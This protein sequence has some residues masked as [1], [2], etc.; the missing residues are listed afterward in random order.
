MIA[1]PGQLNNRAELYH[2]LGV[3]VA[4]G[5]P[6][7]KALEM[8]ST[9]PATRGSRKTIPA[10]IQHLNS[11]L[12][13]SDSMTRVQGW[14][15]EFDIALLSVGEQSG[16]LDASFKLLSTYYAMRAKVIRDTIVG[17][18]IPLVTLHVFL[19]VFPLNLWVAFAQGIIYGNLIQCVPFTIE[20]VV[21]FGVLYGLVFLLI[22]LCQ[23]QR[24]EPWRAVVESFVRMIPVLR[25]A[26]KNL[27]LSRLAGALESAIGAG[28]SVMKGWQLAG[29]ASGSPRLHQ[30]IAGW[31][32][33]LESGMTPAELVNQTGYF[34]TMFA[35]LYHTGEQ[36]GQL[37]D[38]LR[39]L[40]AYYL[41][42]G[43]RKLRFF[44]L[45][46]TGI[47]YGTVALL[48][49]LYVL[50]FYLNLFSGIQKTM[51]GL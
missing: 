22:Y 29:S 28:L 19:L 48:V 18:L 36:S 44:T 25:V 10:L 17:L 14:L 24:G 2:Q 7:I 50:R 38:T 6:L 40:Q 13:F 5:I 23:G 45:L 32:P 12:T 31:I 51:E 1:T 4:A 49:G 11:G 15:P 27:V 30:T 8:A 37:D 35:N 41:E 20:K 39:R 21:L 3:T 26:Q 16:R 42:E 47:V 43:L 9:N 46:V 34:P 33:R